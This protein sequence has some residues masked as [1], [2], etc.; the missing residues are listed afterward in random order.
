MW[1]EGRRSGERGGDAGPAP[2]V[3]QA[4]MTLPELLIAVALVSSLMAAAI[5]MVDRGNARAAHDEFVL[6][7]DLARS[8][9]VQ[10]ARLTELHLDTEASRYWIQVDTAGTGAYDT[11]KMRHV[12]SDGVRLTSD[13]ALLCF[14][15]R[16]LATTRG[17]CEAADAT[18][19]F[20]DHGTAD[21]V[22]TTAAGMVL[23]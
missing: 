6:A 3:G 13:R 7:H 21:S 11:L 2:R 9:A 8:V 14:D 23:R 1:C 12:G 4:G 17:A 22:V 5:P 18:V 15:A 19:V 10:H 20:S 16:G